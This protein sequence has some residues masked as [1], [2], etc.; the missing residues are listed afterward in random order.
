MADHLY[1]TLIARA[2]IQYESGSQTLISTFFK[3]PRIETQGQ[4]EQES[5]DNE[6]AD[7]AATSVSISLLTL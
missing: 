1:Y 3:R 6:F 4:T 2:A 7:V 5:D